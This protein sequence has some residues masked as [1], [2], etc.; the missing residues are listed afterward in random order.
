MIAFTSEHKYPPTVRELCDIIGLASSS[1]MHGYLKRLQLHGLITWEPE[2][3]RTI[4]IV[5]K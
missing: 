3:P 1:T 5:E 2:K 4:S